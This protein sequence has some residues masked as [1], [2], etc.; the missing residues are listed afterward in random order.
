M[1]L[2]LGFS[3]YNIGNRVEE[4]T[5]N[6]IEEMMAIDRNSADEE[7][8]IQNVALTF[9]NSLNLTIKNTG[10]V[11]SEIE[12]VVVFDDRLNTQNYYRV[13]TSLNPV[14]TQKDIGNTSILMNPLNDYT[15]QVLTKLGNIY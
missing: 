8:D 6:I 7:L 1:I 14:E 12:W 15:I 10:N 9:G 11:F 13:E 3:Y 4:N 2:A 5:Q